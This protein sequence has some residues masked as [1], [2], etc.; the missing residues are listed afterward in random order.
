MAV[1]Y[2]CDREGCSRAWDDMSNV[3][4]VVS[5][6]APPMPPLHFCS[7]ECAEAYAAAALRAHMDAEL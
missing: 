4:L 7:F 1:T 2:R 6:L 3:P 5:R